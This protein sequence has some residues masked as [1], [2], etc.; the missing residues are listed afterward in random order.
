MPSRFLTGL[1][2]KL[3]EW[4][5]K[6]KG[7]KTNPDTLAQL[8]DEFFTEDLPD[9]FPT[10]DSEYI[11]TGSPGTFKVVKIQRSPPMV[12]L[13]DT[14]SEMEYPVELDLFD[15]IFTPAPSGEKPK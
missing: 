3:F 12:V 10:P 8:G 9:P 15:A 6:F 5:L 1:S 4:L 7:V 11:V 14:S 13:V 2:T